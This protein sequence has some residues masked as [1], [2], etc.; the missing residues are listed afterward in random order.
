MNRRIF[1][2]LFAATTAAIL[3]GPRL[4]TAD[5]SEA[6]CC[7]WRLPSVWLDQ[8]LWIVAQQLRD[9]GE[10]VYTCAAQASIGG[11]VYPRGF[12]PPPSVQQ[13]HDNLLNEYNKVF[14]VVSA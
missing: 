10:M 11:T 12:P 3:T 9:Y 6:T 14:G 8:W 2:Q 13:Y 4:L 7:L 5:T 1:L